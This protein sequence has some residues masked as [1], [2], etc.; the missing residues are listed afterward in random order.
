MLGLET[1]AGGHQRIEP[2][3]ELVLL[4]CLLQEPK[5]CETF[6]LPFAEEMVVPQCVW[7]SQ[8]RAAAWAAE[9]PNWVIR[10]FTCEMPET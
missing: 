7:Q 6:R 5:Q 10:K 2:M 1:A 3:V 9:H 8:L 4:A